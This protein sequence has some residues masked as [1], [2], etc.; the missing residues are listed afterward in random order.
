MTFPRILVA[1]LVILS[2]GRL[3]GAACCEY[4]G[5]CVDGIDAS[6]CA[7]EFAGTFA[8]DG[9]CDVGT[10]LCL[11]SSCPEGSECSDGS[12]CTEGDVCGDGVCAGTPV[13][14]DDGLSCTADACDAE[15]G[16]SH[17]VEPGFCAIAGACVP[18][19]ASNP[20]NPCEQCDPTTAVSAWV[21]VAVGTSCSDGNACNGA[22]TCQ[23]GTCTGG[24]APSCNDGNGCTTD[25]CDPETGCRYTPVANGTS[26]SDG[27][28]CN[29]AETCAD[30]GCTAGAAGPCDDHFLCWRVTGARASR[31]SPPY[32]AFVKQRDVA[33][34]DALSGRRRS[35]IV[36][37]VA[38]CNPADKNGES[39]D[40]PLHEDHHESYRLEPAEGVL[41]S[42][43]PTTSVGIQ[44][45]FGSLVLQVRSPEALL[46]PA[47]KALG[48][49]G[50]PPRAGDSLDHFQCYRTKTAAGRF[51]E[52]S[53]QVTD[54][55][56]GPL[57]FVVTKPSHFCVPADKRGESPSAPSHDGM[58]V[59]YLLKTPK[60]Q[61][62]A[63]HLISTRTQFGNEILVTGAAY[64]LC[65]P[66]RR[67]G[68]APTATEER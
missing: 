29:G 31:G 47:A 14:C 67:V 26:C 32:P 16:C 58:L 1:A 51:E 55:F 25:I 33:V 50:A 20:A 49:G 40:A 61:A 23:T 54:Q 28:A 48:A 34:A 9:T 8:E 19:G 62:P 42:R 41:Q 52:R 65:V 21:P 37:P 46:V 6:T 17:A 63:T 44:N 60:G 38:I 59:C 57:R 53:I 13:S 15:A 11:G 2:T 7:V 10:G 56:G 4:A 64:E 5:G 24:T 66:S 18:A 43:L 36:K 22:E 35:D 3:A 68:A 30:G 45:Q 27:N 12:A 39:P